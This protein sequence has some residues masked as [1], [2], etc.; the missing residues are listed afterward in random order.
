MTTDENDLS[1]EM[2]SLLSRFAHI[3]SD[4]LKK[5]LVY[6]LSLCSDERLPEV[7]DLDPA[8]LIDYAENTW[9]VRRTDD[10]ADYA[11]IDAGHDISSPSANR[12]PGRTLAEATAKDAFPRVKRYFDR[13]LDTPCITHVTG[14][15]YSERSEPARGERLMMPI[16]ENGTPRY[17]LGITVHNLAL[18]GAFRNAPNRQILTHTPIFSGPSS[19]TIRAL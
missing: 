15:L 6:W 7:G 12:L 9:L 2:R 17:I 18:D 19:V 4:P 11:Y 13:T 14:R 16:L 1:L 3:E 5:A 10:G 8:P